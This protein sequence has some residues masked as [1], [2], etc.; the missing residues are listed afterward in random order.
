[1]KVIPQGFRFQDIKKSSTIEDGIVRFGYGGTF[2]PGM[3]DP[4]ALLAYLT[5]LE[6]SIKF[7]FHIYTM[8]VNLVNPYLFDHR[9]IL[10]EPVSREELLNVFST[11]QFVVNISNKGKSQTPSKLIDY[12]IIEKPILQIDSQFIDIN[13]VDAFLQRNFEGALRLENISDYQIE[14]VVSKFLN[15]TECE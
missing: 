3:R 5:S 15:L 8:Q 13:A 7:E 6:D 10:H 11:F 12:G 1:L 9:I 2:I 14:N 4:S